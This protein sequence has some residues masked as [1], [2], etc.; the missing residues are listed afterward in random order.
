[1]RLMLRWGFTLFQAGIFIV[2]DKLV[3]VFREQKESRNSALKILTYAMNGHEGKANCQTFV[4]ILG[5]GVLFPL[6]MKP[7]KGNKKTGETKTKNEGK[8]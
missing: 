5:L 6:F 2:S 3:S 1:M 7:P 4:D 8:N